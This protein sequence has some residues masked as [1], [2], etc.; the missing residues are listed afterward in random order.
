MLSMDILAD[1]LRTSAKVISENCT[2]RACTPPSLNGAALYTSG[3][4]L[5]DTVYV[6]EARRLP[7][8]WKRKAHLSLVIAGPVAEEYF[9]GADVEYICLAETRLQEV[10]NAVLQ[11]FRRYMNFDD[12]LKESLIRNAPIDFLCETFSRFIS[13]PVVVLDWRLRVRYMSQGVKTLFRWD[14]DALSGMLMLPYEYMNLIQ[15]A[16]KDVTGLSGSETR[17]LQDDRLPRAMITAAN[18]AGTNMVFVFEQDAPLTR[19]SLQV[20]D[21]VV[22]YLFAS[23][24]TQPQDCTADSLSA[25]VIDL[26]NGRQFCDEELAQI[27]GMVGYSR[28]DNYCCIVVKPADHNRNVLYLNISY[29][30]LE[31]QFK[32]CVAFLYKGDIVMVV[33]L[34]RSGILPRDIPNR[35]GEMLRDGLFHAGL[36]FMYWDFATTKIY[37][38]QA[39]SAYELGRIYDP[40]IWCFSFEKYALEYF[41]HYGASKIPARH[42]CH[43]GLVQLYRYDQRHQTELLITLET[44]LTCNCNAALAAKKLFIHRNTFYQRLAKIRGIVGIDTEDE[45]TRL[46]LFMSS[47]LISLYYHEKERGIDLFVYL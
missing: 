28:S 1:A 32:E 24:E 23:M 41:A 42:L 20:T 12:A 39:I 46:Y 43:P 14:R 45:K 36:S 8:R 22:A 9:Q 38:E 40:T 13:N 4:V 26:L 6:A 29:L 44:Y 15:I 5:Q 25:F 10:L 3:P 37:Y 34:D 27:L 31:S 21:Y 33:N 2:S 17:L 47:Y 19:V 11:V 16:Q 7:V 30:K 18:E 35:I